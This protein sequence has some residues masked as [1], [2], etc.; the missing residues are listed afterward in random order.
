MDD[1]PTDIITTVTFLES[2]YAALIVRYVHCEACKGTEVCASIDVRVV[3]VLLR[4]LT[5][6]LVALRMGRRSL[7]WGLTF[8]PLSELRRHHETSRPVCGGGPNLLGHERK[9]QRADWGKVFGKCEWSSEGPGGHWWQ[10]SLPPAASLST[11]MTRAS[12]GQ[13]L[14]SPGSLRPSCPPKQQ[15]QQ[16]QRTNKA[17]H[18]PDWAALKFPFPH[19]RSIIRWIRRIK[20]T[21]AAKHVWSSLCLKYAADSNRLREDFFN[22]L[23]SRFAKII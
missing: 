3:L 15:E 16:Q 6:S 4:G 14:C 20:D 2:G 9:K 21:E 12:D 8:P 10:L 7:R 23:K 17:P 11:L 13:S 19:S 18:G 22:Y 1:P 5:E